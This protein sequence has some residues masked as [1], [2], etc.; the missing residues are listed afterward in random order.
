MRLISLNWSD[1]TGDLTNRYDA[2]LLQPEEKLGDN[3]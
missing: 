3:T 2:I 1:Y